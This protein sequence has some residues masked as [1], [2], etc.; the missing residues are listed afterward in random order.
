MM[1]SQREDHSYSLAGGT[2]YSPNVIKFSMYHVRFL[3]AFSC[4]IIFISFHLR[5]S[6][7]VPNSYE[8]MAFPEE[9]QGLVG[10]FL[11]APQK[12]DPQWKPMCALASRHWSAF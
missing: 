6:N 5:F 4:L 12:T 1:V 3:P 8:N 9:H 10:C 2:V 7:S 11:L